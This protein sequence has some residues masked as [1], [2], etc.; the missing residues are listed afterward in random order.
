MSAKYSTV[1]LLV[2]NSVFLGLAAVAVGLRFY[3]IHLTARSQHLS[4][5]L[6]IGGLVRTGSFMLT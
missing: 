5:Y 2:V 1:S 3:S 6:I 4:D